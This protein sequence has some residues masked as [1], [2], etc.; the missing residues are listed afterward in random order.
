MDAL[1][2][3]K[4]EHDVIER[5][6]G[7]LQQAVSRIEALQ[8]VPEGFAAWAIEFFGQF[9]DRCQH[10][11]EED[12]LFPLLEECGIPRDGGPIGVM[13]SEHDIGRDCVGHMKQATDTSTPDLAASP[14]PPMSTLPCCA[15]T[16]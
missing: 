6:L 7:F 13:L 14:L 15:N 9:A 10:G 2:L 5:V 3:L 11:K 1:D 8:D 12:I 4:Q 16:S